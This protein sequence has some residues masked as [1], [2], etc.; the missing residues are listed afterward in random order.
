MIIELDRMTQMRRNIHQAQQDLVW[1]FCGSQAI[2]IMSK[3]FSKSPFNSKIVMNFYQNPQLA[4]LQCIDYPAF[5]VNSVEF[6]F[7]VEQ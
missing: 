2:S 7:E 3:L 1:K 4:Q 6:R 5:M